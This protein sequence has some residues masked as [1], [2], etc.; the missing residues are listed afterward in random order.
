MRGN[1]PVN[2]H[3]P[4]FNQN[5]FTMTMTHDLERT[6]N[7]TLPYFALDDSRLDKTYEAGKWSI[8]FIL[9]HLADAE[10]VLYDRI[11][12]SISRP[13]QVVWG[14][15]QDAWAAN[16]DYGNKPLE[17]SGSIYTSCRAGI[18]YLAEKNYTSKGHHEM[19]H[20]G[21]GKKTLKDVFDK[22]V[23]HNERHLA[24]IQQ[25]LGE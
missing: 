12:R 24:Q 23:W 5:Q 19:I 13:G 9:H 10:T 4:P 11:R 15:D 7:L 16:L 6:L 8:R 20:S 22:V 21:D 3:L 17:I 18:I 14:F 1:Y 25:A 2:K